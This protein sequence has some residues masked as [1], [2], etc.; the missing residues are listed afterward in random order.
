VNSA[1]PSFSKEGAVLRSSNLHAQSLYVAVLALQDAE[2]SVG[3]SGW[4]C[5]VVVRYRQADAQ[6]KVNVYEDLH[7]L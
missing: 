2:T 6:R 4:L 7:R 3:G 1:W 5:C